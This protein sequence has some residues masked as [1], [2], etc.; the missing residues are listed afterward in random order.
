MLAPKYV[1]GAPVCAWTPWCV[2][3][4]ILAHCNVCRAV[5][6]TGQTWAQ[7]PWGP[8]AATPKAH[9]PSSANTFSAQGRESERRQH[10]LVPAQVVAQ[11]FAPGHRAV[12]CQQ[13]GCQLTRC[14]LVGIAEVLN[15][16]GVNG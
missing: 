10:K 6:L 9:H 13:S 2:Q 16:V 15:S 4:S 1:G 8:E 14:T 11:S 3:H 7:A 5:G 12:L